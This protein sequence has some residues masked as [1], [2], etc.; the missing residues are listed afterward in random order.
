MLSILKSKN[1]T[2]GA[3]FLWKMAKTHEEGEGKGGKQLNQPFHLEKKK[4]IDSNAQKH[5]VEFSF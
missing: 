1:Y 2:S 4:I 5:C 3:Y